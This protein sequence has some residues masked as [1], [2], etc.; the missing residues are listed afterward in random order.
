MDV[1]TS[2]EVGSV[3]RKAVSLC[4]YPIDVDDKDGGNA[5]GND[6]GGDWKLSG[7]IDGRNEGRP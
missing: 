7:A 1:L 4:E 2:R 6:S 3:L 5:E